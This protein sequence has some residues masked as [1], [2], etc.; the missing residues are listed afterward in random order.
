VDKLSYNQVLVNISVIFVQRSLPSATSTATTT[1]RG[2]ER[3]T[4]SDELIATDVMSHGS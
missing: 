4:T 3:Q 2:R 1:T